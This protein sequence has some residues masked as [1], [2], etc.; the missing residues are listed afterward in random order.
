MA[1]RSE[2]SFIKTLLVINF[3]LSVF[4]QLLPKR[5]W[6]RKRR[7]VQAPGDPGRSRG[8]PASRPSSLGQPAS[9]TAAWFGALSALGTQ[10]SFSRAACAHTCRPACSVGQTT[11]LNS[12]EHKRI[13]PLNRK[14]SLSELYLK[15]E[16][17]FLSVI[18]R[19]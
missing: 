10:P 8:Q 18:E 13:P 4:Q 5:G 17:C 15:A 9:P 6:A 11:L 7:G 19:H 2:N 3:Q 14:P 12:R 16:Y 1:Y